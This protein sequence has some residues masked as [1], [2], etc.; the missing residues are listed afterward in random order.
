MYFV[1][2]LVILIGIIVAKK[3]GVRRYEIGKTERRRE[4]V[5]EK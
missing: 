1:S 3:I 2:I 4:V 5:K